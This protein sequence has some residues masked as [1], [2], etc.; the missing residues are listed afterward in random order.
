MNSWTHVSAS[1]L[2]LFSRCPR[3]WYYQYILGLP[4]PVG[5]AAELGKRVHTCLEERLIT[6]EWPRLE[7]ADPKVLAIAKSGEQ[8]LPTGTVQVEESFS[9]VPPGSPVPF[10]GFIDVLDPASN[11]VIDHKTTGNLRWAKESAELQIDAQA[12]LYSYYA[13]I[14][15]K[16]EVPI[17][18]RHIYY[19]TR[20]PGA[21]TT[22]CQFNSIDLTAGMNRFVS[23]AN[24]MFEVSTCA[25][26]E[27][28]QANTA[29]CGDFG[30][31]PFRDRCPATKGESEMSTTKISAFEAI[32]G[33]A[34][35]KPIETIDIGRANA[36]VEVLCADPKVG[37]E[38]AKTLVQGID[39]LVEPEIANEKGEDDKAI[40]RRGRPAKGPFLADGRQVSKLKKGELVQVVTEMLGDHNPETAIEVAEI[41]GS[42]DEVLADYSRLYIGC[43]PRKAEYSPEFLDDFLEKFQSE[44]AQDEGVDHYLCVEYG[45]G[46]K[47]VAAKLALSLRNQET[48][49]PLIMVADAQS[50]SSTPVLEVINRYYDEVVERWGA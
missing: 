32:V 9:I 47:L 7:V 2:R 6:G 43:I 49:L 16:W 18:F 35:N 48:Q 40:T 37:E 15:L 12:I 28:V 30:G 27:K 10:V 34:K 4:S 23:Q 19:C 45:K 5:P 11:A 24:E 38:V 42:K 14:E 29:A 20:S 36:L 22:E 44:V 3:K 13:W 50:P 39:K 17:Q 21:I 8:H 31:C 1:Q 46:P 33:R 26:E 41:S 25:S